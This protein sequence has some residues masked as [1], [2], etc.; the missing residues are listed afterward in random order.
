LAWEVVHTLGE[1]DA[2][3]H[4]IL[5]VVGDLIADYLS[6]LQLFVNLDDIMEACEIE[7]VAVL[8]KIVEPLVCES[9]DRSRDCCSLHKHIEHCIHIASVFPLLSHYLWHFSK[10]ITVA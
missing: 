7:N 2:I 8:F 5:V 4:C 3:R 1:D 10:L 6:K 9:R